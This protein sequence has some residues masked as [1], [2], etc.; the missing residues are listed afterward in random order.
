MA[1]VE[2]LRDVAARAAQLLEDGVVLNPLGDDAHPQRVAEVD[3][4]ADQG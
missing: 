1:D 4:G 2:P 3:G